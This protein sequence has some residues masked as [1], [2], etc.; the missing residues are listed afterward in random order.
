MN[1]PAPIERNVADSPGTQVGEPVIVARNVTVGYKLHRERKMLTALRDISLTINK[2]EF[3]VLLGPSGCGKTTFINAISGIVLPWEGSIEVNGA[4]VTGPGPDR[5]MVFQDYALMPWRTVEANLRMPFEF[6]NLGL[7]KDEVDARI[8]RYLE[9]VDLKGFEKSFPYELSGG[10]KQRVGIARAL[11]TEPTILLADEPFAA[12]DAMT[13]EAMQSELERIVMATGQTVVFI[14]HSIDEA[15]TLGDRIA[16]ISRRPGRIKEVVDVNL[17]RP[18]F[19]GDVKSRPE[20]AK[21]RERIWDLV[22]AE[23]LSGAHGE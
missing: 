18:R 7:S 16:V 14:T 17:P 19:D 3:V 13:R 1:R 11:A 6:Q 23:A 2:G 20:Y 8:A 9:L 22:K 5:A 4:P 21:I 12:I 10:M 15:I